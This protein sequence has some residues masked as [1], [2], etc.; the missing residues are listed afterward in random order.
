MSI[1]ISQTYGTREIQPPELHGWS[2]RVPDGSVVFTVTIT[3][4]IS[5]PL[6]HAAAEIMRN[7]VDAIH[8]LAAQSGP[9]D[10]GGT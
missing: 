6:D 2:H 7:A 9:A 10:G 1:T 4:Q 5:S 8:A 3:D